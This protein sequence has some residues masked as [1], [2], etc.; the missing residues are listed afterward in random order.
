MVS[1]Q[2]IENTYLAY[3]MLGSGLGMGTAY[4]YRFLVVLVV[5]SLLYK[6]NWLQE[7][8]YTPLVI[9]G[10][11]VSVTDISQQF[12]ETT[13]VPGILTSYS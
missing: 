13:E 10:S 6:V 11:G 5:L 2:N 7:S 4:H 3:Y 1:K 12:R 8:L 9:V